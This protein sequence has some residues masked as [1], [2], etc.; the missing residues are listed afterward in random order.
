MNQTILLEINNSIATLSFNRPQAM[1]SYNLELAQAFAEATETVKNDPTIRAVLLRGNGAMFM[2]GGDIQFFSQHLDEMADQVSVMM[3]YVKQTV[4]NLQTMSKPVLASVHGSVAGIGMSFMAACDLVI[5]A[6][7]T[8][9]TLAYGALGI[10]PDGGASYF[11]PRLVG[12]KKAM[13][14]ALFSE[15]FDA[16]TAQEMGLINWVVPEAELNTQTEKYAQK[17]AKGAS[18]AFAEMK[19]LINQTGDNSLS[20]QLELEEK[21]FTKCAQSDDFKEGVR[22]FL[23]KRKAEFKGL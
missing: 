23:A 22:A 9:F 10:S 17:L 13:Q 8:K 16:Q 3:P 6:D 12:T 21:S 20:E 5:A 1:N 4:L 15:L 19:Q 18:L 2:A 7:T 14:L 11:L